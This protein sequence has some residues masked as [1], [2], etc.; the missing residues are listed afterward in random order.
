MCAGVCTDVWI[1]CIRI[2]ICEITMV[3]GFSVDLTLLLFF[4]ERGSSKADRTK[5]R[6]MHICGLASS[7]RSAESNFA[8]SIMLC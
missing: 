8:S 2:Q 6:F 3:S 4:R 7:W 1:M 5:N